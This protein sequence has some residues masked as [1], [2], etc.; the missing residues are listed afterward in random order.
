MVVPM[1]CAVLRSGIV[2]PVHGRRYA[3]RSR[4]ARGGT[5]IR[6]ASTAHCITMYGTEIAYGR[7]VCG[8][9]IAYGGGFR[10]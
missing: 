2:V 8:P 1:V 7:T 10:R 9:E 4:A 6:Y 3:R 5:A